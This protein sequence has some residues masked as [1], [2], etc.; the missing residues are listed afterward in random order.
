MAGE[1]DQKM[2]YEARLYQEQLR[3]LDGE[4]ER[5]TMTA[6]ELNNSLKA[7]E[8]LKEDSV[9]VPIGG[10]AMVNAQI[11]TTEVLVPIGGGYL[12]N[13][14]KHEA[15]EEVKRRMVSTDAAITKLRSEFD[16]IRGKLIDVGTKIEAMNV[17]PGV[18]KR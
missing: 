16:K 1:E 6:M 5:I 15:I 2:V 13:L 7:V 4:I 18:G 12:M 11:S 8:S 17:K 9:F 3:L 10:G 14:K